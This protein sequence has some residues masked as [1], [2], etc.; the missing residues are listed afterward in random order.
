M[1]DDAGIAVLQPDEIARRV[2]AHGLDQAGGHGATLLF[3]EKLPRR[4]LRGQRRTEGARADLG[5]E[6][7]GRAQQVGLGAHLVEALRVAPAT[8]PLVVLL[9][10]LQPIGILHT[11]LAQQLCRLLRM[12]ADLRHLP[13]I[14]RFVLL[15]HARL[16][17]DDGGVHRQRG[18]HRAALR[19]GGPAQLARGEQRDGGRVQRVR[20][21][22]ERKTAVVLAHAQVQRRVGVALHQRDVAVGKG[23]E[24]R[25]FRAAAAQAAQEFVQGPDLP[26]H[27]V[28]PGA[29][30]DHGAHAA[31]AGTTGRRGGTTR[32]SAGRGAGGFGLH[33]ID[34]AAALHQRMQLVGVLQL[35]AGGQQQAA[36][37]V[38]HGEG[39]GRARRSELHELAQGHVGGRCGCVHAA[40]VGLRR[41]TASAS[42]GATLTALLACG[43][44]SLLQTCRTP[45]A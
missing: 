44:Q 39:Q 27:A 29:L 5:R 4:E 13:G 11:G 9:D 25:R 28:E 18:A 35:F 7:I 12:S 1:H 3:L 30:A 43:T 6:D 42:S 33:R 14:G 19:F 32:G 22:V 16:Q 37:A 17:L 10:G 23:L 15:G 20:Q 26:L 40:L 8:R 31:A 2:D 21:C 24:L 36:H 45:A 38:Q 34:A 41:C